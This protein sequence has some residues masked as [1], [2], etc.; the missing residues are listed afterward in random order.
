MN[1]NIARQF[2]DK[3]IP[4]PPIKR[5]NVG[6][7]LVITIPYAYNSE[8]IAVEL[9]PIIGKD[10]KITIQIRAFFR[11]P[12]PQT[13]HVICNERKVSTFLNLGNLEEYVSHHPVYRN[14]GQAS[15][16]LIPTVKDFASRSIEIVKGLLQNLPEPQPNHYLALTRNL[17]TT[18]KY[19]IEEKENDTF[20]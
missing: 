3:R 9:I 8:R 14:V 7:E 10:K 17:F 18:N 5:Y 15:D 12:T 19:I 2:H 1:E 20:N 4:R 16:A 11:R 13:P 6:D